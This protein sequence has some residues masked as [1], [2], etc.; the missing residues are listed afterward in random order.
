MKK[1][2][3]IFKKI[4][5]RTYY[6]ISPCPS[7][8]S[9]VTGRYVKLHRETDTEWQINESLRHGELIKAVNEVPLRN[10]FCVN[11]KYEWSDDVKLQF[12]SQEKINEEKKKRLTVEIL[13]RRIAEQR[14]A[15]KHDHS[16]LK[17]IKRFIGKI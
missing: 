14:E 2:N 12:L 10:C 1:P 8:G 13:N 5:H 9:P 7:C 4:I 3:N 11:C 16:L 17:P 15:Y 6:Y